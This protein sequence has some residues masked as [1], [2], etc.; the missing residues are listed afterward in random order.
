MPGIPCQSVKLRVAV[1]PSSRWNVGLNLLTASGVYARGDENNSDLNG[2]IG[3]YTVV[4]LD[5]HFELRRTIRL[6]A[7]IDNLLNR[8]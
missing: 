2:R 7:N 6:F 8:S 3:G 1:A 5:T 4:N